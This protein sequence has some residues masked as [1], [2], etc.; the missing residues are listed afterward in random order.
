MMIYCK[1]LPAIS[2]PQFI[3]YLTIIS[4][5]AGAHVMSVEIGEIHL[6][7]YRY[8]LFFMWVIFVSA[9]FLN[10]GR[11]NLSHIKVKLYLQ[12]F[13][14]WL[15]YAFLSIIWAAD[16]VKALRDIIFLFMGVSIVFLH[17][18]YFQ[19]LNYLKLLF[20]L[21]LLIFIA[22]LPIGIWEIITGNHLKGAGLFGETRE[23]VAASPSTVFYNP[24]DYAAYIVLSLPMILVWIRLYPKLVG[25]MFGILIIILGLWILTMTYSRSCYI[26]LLTGFAFWFIFLLKL[27]G[28]IKMMVIGASICILIIIALQEQI[29]DTLII[30]RSEMNSVL[31]IGSQ[32]DESIAVRINL[33][34][35]A[36]HFTAQSRG[37]GVGAGNAEYYM[38][39]YKI[40][41]V[42]DVTNLH[43]WWA[44]I[45]LNYGVF[46]FTGYVVLYISL[47]WNLWRIHK[48]VSDR[49]ERMICESLLV[50]LVSFFMASIGS[51]SIIALS[52]HWIYFGFVLAFINYYR[53]SETSRTLRCTS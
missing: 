27:K 50:G 41:P 11:L 48:R 3:L 17:V 46:I 40:Y 24:N 45:L 38:E 29:Q 10:E 26:A 5:F 7:P 52:P 39:N 13:V 32:D 49:T 4:A 19:N 43:N 20:G 6:F 30:M 25:R 21:L 15:A 47:L 34:K 23:L 33:I 2:F 51:S 16:Q 1:R 14:L 37:F 12:F 35:N 9:I 53:I 8:L 36:L 31:A 44:E 18:Y 22:L 42:G 28:K